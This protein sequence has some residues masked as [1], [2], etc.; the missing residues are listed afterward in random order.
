MTEP[1]HSKLGAS[2]ASRWMACPGSVAL[3]A[4][5]GKGGDDE[6]EFAAE[7]T[8]AHEVAAECLRTVSDA[9]EHVGRTFHNHVLDYDMADHVQKYINECRRISVG[10]ETWIEHRITSNLHADLFGTMDFAALSEY[11]LK[12]RDL[13]F[14][15]GLTVEVEDNAQLKYYAFGML[16]TPD[17]FDGVRYVEIGIVQPRKDH[18]N[19]PVRVVTH[20][21]EEIHEWGHG[22][23]IPMMKRTER[24]HTLDPGEHCRFCPARFVCPALQGIFQYAS[25][26]PPTSV[27][28]LSDTMLGLAYR[29]TGPARIFINAIETEALSRLNNGKKV[30]GLK[31]VDKRADRVYRDGATDVLVKAFGKKAYTEP[32]LR[33]PAQME[34]LGPEAVALVKKWAYTPKTGQT[35]ASD[36]DRRAT[37]TRQ[38]GKE[39]WKG[40]VNGTDDEW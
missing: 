39:V 29:A 35:V 12:L 32:A 33:T 30:P 22:V 26:T 16:Q 20:T 34:K 25:Q 11:S 37:V 14:G 23:L 40:V 5:L 38:S 6:S 21:A 7:G 18:P 10:A 2:G 19:G 17:L 1:V 27:R 4:A 36:E 24:D 31:L 28:E 13:K 8:A 9:W 15:A 3:T